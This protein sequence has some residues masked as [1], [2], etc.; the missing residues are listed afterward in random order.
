MKVLSLKRRKPNES[1][2]QGQYLLFFR[3]KEKVLG[4]FAI[5]L[6]Y[7]TS[8]LT[9]EQEV[10][11]FK[12]KYNLFQVQNYTKHK[13]LHPYVTKKIVSS[14]TKTKFMLEK[15]KK[16]KMTED[17]RAFLSEEMVLPSPAPVGHWYTLVMIFL[18]F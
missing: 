2:G 11:P 9:E 13:Q 12:G 3:Q 7:L 15:K 1:R 8:A 14:H 4:M 6:W 16:K 17:T 18:E 5:N 10:A